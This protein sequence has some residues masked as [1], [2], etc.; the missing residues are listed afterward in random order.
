[1]IQTEPPIA[2]NRCE[3]V[4][5]TQLTDGLGLAET[6]PP[7]PAQ[8][9]VLSVM[10]DCTAHELLVADDYYSFGIGRPMS[11]LQARRLFNGPDRPQRLGELCA[12]APYNATLACRTVDADI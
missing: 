9:A 3:E 4:F 7:S 1:L 11:R 12:L 6:A 5:K 8:A 10:D 2:R